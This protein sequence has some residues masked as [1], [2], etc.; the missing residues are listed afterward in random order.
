M[1]SPGEINWAVQEGFYSSIY[2]LSTLKMFRGL[3]VLFVDS[4]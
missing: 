4:G 2:F 1:S 3:E